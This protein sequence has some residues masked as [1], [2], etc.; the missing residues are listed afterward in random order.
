MFKAGIATKSLNQP[1][2]L[3]AVVRNKSIMFKDT[4]NSYETAKLGS[5]KLIPNEHQI[6][7]LQKDY[8][9]MNEMFMGEI[10]AFEEIVIGLEQLENLVNS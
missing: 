6:S 7:E 5:L 1:E 9:A 3:A 8:Q 10:V 4:A 2:L